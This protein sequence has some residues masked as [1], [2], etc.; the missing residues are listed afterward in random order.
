MA[1]VWRRWR[2]RRRNAVDADVPDVASTPVDDADTA[3]VDGDVVDECPI[4]M[5]A[6]GSVRL[7]PCRHGFCARCLERAAP[8]YSSRCAVCRTTVVVAPGETAPTRCKN[9]TVVHVGTSRW[10]PGISL[11]HGP[12]N[13]STITDLMVDDACF[14]AGLR[15]G[16]AVLSLNGIP[17]GDARHATDIFDTAHKHAMDVVCVVR[18]PTRFVLPCAEW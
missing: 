5:D 11:R 18:R 2:R 8:R 6:P 16:D 14:R 9:A 7:Q 17:V 12:G 10:H 3:A 1:T 13:A 15:V 4:C